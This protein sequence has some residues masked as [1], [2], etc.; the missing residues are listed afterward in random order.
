[1]TCS[2]RGDPIP[3]G[4]YWTKGE[5][6]ESGL[7]LIRVARDETG[8][9]LPWVHL[10]QVHI[11]LTRPGEVLYGN[12]YGA[13]P[14][15][16]AYLGSVVVAWAEPTGENFEAAQREIQ[17]SHARLY[18]K[19]SQRSW[20]LWRCEKCGRDRK[21][22]GPEPDER[23]TCDWCFQKGQGRD[24]VVF[25]QADYVPKTMDCPA[26]CDVPFC[27]EHQAHLDDCECKP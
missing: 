16:S 24:T 6:T 18:G 11:D 26:G 2:L 12:N 1:M 15:W 8:S 19:T 23:L 10:A 3:F 7:C 25:I 13:S 5:P 20:D 14:R 17:D 27:V 22:M 21:T 9:G 4:D